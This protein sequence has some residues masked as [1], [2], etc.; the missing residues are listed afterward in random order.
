MIMIDNKTSCRALGFLVWLRK[1]YNGAAEDTYKEMAKKYG[2][3]R[4]SAIRLYLIE[5]EKAGYIQ[6]ENRSKHTQRYVINEDKF[7]SL[8]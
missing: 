1:F 3:C 2:Q 5:L 7:Q 6:I 4:Y 8:I